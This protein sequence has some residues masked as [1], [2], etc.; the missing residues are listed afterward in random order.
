MFEHYSLPYSQCP[1][2]TKDFTY[3]EENSVYILNVIQL[4]FILQH[5]NKTVTQQTA[6][7]LTNLGWH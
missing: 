3:T 6:F 5:I 7:V 1:H 2:I 4:Q